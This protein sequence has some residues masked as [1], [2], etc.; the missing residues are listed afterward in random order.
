MNECDECKPPKIVKIRY[1]SY[2]L[3]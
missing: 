3:N 1:I 2:T